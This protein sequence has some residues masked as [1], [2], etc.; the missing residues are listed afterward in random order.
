MDVGYAIFSLRRQRKLQR[1][2]N[3][4]AERQWRELPG[5]GVDGMMSRLERTPGGLGQLTYSSGEGVQPMR[6][7]KPS[8][9]AGAAA[10]AAGAFIG[11]SAL[12]KVSAK[13]SAERDEYFAEQER[14]QKQS[15]AKSIAYEIELINGNLAS[16]H[17]SPQERQR[18]LAR[19]STLQA[20]LA[21]LQ[22]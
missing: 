1:E 10:F 2:R 9:L 11:Y 8:K 5:G 13:R 21:A 22:V 19:I 18:Y 16:A 17:Y 3:E 20:E 15:R 12:D 4:E 7:Q 14:K 6:Q